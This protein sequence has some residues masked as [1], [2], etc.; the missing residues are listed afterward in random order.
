MFLQ[1]AVHVQLTVNVRID[2]LGRLNSPSGSAGIP[3]V[4]R[5]TKPPP[6]VNRATKPKAPTQDHSYCNMAPPVNR[7]SKYKRSTMPQPEPSYINCG[8]PPQRPQNLPLVKILNG[9]PYVGSLPNQRSTWAPKVEEDA[10]YCVME[11]PTRSEFTRCYSLEKDERQKSP[12]TDQ[13]YED[14]ST[15]RTKRL[16]GTK[17]SSSSSSS[18]GDDDAYTQM[19]PARAGSTPIQVRAFTI[20]TC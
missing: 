8:T 6:Q 15:M 20:N 16:S 4:D 10:E 5:S 12:V 3:A 1:F 13:C 7:E 18:L 11:P 19:T 2:Y 14:M 17:S 9:N